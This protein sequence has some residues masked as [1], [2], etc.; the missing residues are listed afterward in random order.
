MP[1]DRSVEECC[2]LQVEMHLHEPTRLHSSPQA[3]SATSG[4]VV[5]LIADH[6]AYS[7]IEPPSASIVRPK[8]SFLE[9][10]SSSVSMISGQVIRCSMGF[11]AKAKV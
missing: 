6:N 9:H 11:K 8:A 3:G 2:L 7:L 10:R 5:V 4:D 1:I